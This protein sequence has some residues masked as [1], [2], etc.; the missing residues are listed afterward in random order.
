LTI[1]RSLNIRA[2]VWSK[3]PLNADATSI[4]RD[5]TRVVK[6]SGSER[7]VLRGRLRAVAHIGQV[8]LVGNSYRVQL[9]KFKLSQGGIEDRTD[10][11]D[12]E[13][14]GRY[15][16]DRDIKGRYINDRNIKGR[17]IKDK[18]IKY[19]ISK[20]EESEDQGSSPCVH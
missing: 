6:R 18:I 16:K 20:A 15:I 3:V 2:V 11:R 7:V 12:H 14:R 17:K 4:N 5:I 13:Y 10:F 1:R 19:H 8:N 9:R